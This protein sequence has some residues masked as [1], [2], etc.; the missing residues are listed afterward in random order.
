MYKDYNKLTSAEQKKLQKE[1]NKNYKLTTAEI[2]KKI[3][4]ILNAKGNKQKKLLK[5]LTPLIY[6]LWN[7]NGKEIIYASQVI[8]E[9]TWQFYEYAGNKAKEID[10]LLDDKIIN[11]KVKEAL[12]R[13]KKMVK[14]ER[15]VKAN[16]K[17]TDKQINNVVKKSIKKNNKDATKE[18]KKKLE[19][20]KRK[21]QNIARNETNFHESVAKLEAGKRQEANGNTMVKTWIYTW[22]SKDHRKAHIDADKQ[23]VVGV[24][25]MFDVGGYKTLAPHQF[26]IASQDINCTC[27]Y[28]LEFAKPV[29]TSLKE[30][31]EFKE[32]RL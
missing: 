28:K 8:L 22:A 19:A 5:E 24:N 14:W 3:E 9:V 16:A 23:T 32:T 17:K 25:T 10:V 26:G 20:D 4:Q 2:D 21:A 1:I 27:D 13:R 29:E 31:E 6:A 11:A 30:F 12:D 18:V 7:L 15:V